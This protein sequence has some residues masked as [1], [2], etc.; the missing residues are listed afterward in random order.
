MPS[1]NASHKVNQD[2]PATPLATAVRGETVV[3]KAGLQDLEALVNLEESSFAIDR[4]SR[5]SFRYLL[6]K[7]NAETLLAEEGK[8]AIGYAMLLFNTGTSL[9]RLYSIAVLPEYQGQGLGGE[10]LKLAE[11]KARQHECI[12]L[13]LEVR[14]DNLNAIRI[15]EK[16]GYKRIGSAKDYYEDH[17]DAVRMEKNLA[18]HL[19]PDIMRTPYYEQTLEFTCGPATLM[20]AMNALNKDIKLDRQLE[21]RL[22]RE[23]T[24]I[25]MTSGHGGCDPYGMALAAYNRGFDVE[26][27]VNDPG[28]MF[29]D[30]VRSED[31]KEVM[32]LVQEDFISQIRSLQ[33]GLNHGALNVAQIQEKFEAG[34]VPIVLISS[35]RIYHE[36][37]PHWLVVTGFDEHYIYVHDPLVDY[38]ASKSQ[39]DVVNMPILRKDFERMARYGKSSQ[40]AVIIIKKRG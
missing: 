15:Y 22:W 2:S 36:K 14:S 17:M 8:Q 38:D 37:S 6:S 18:P 4:F 25:F 13:R 20:M 27:Y 1:E 9:A 28:A 12:G 11:E 35:Y 26:I 39:T 10:L 31:K 40:K 3:R 7:A 29:I 32:R 5:R 23:S 34:G 30:S 21:L 16:H 19:N 33:I 24:T